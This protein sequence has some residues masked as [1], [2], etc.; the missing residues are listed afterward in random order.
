MFEEQ[1]AGMSG[2]GDGWYDTLYGAAIGTAGT[3]VPVVGISELGRRTGQAIA[4]EANRLF[5]PK[6]GEN[7]DAYNPLFYGNWN[8]TN[9]ATE[10]Y[11]A[12]RSFFG[13]DGDDPNQD[14]PWGLI[15]VAG[16]VAVVVIAVVK[17]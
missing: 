10:G 9:A 14:F 2:L 3:L 16:I 1:Q 12:V 17:K 4:D 15:I 6:P 5:V 13:G 7:R 11:D 8:L